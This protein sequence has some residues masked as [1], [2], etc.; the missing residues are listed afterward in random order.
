MH[1]LCP[2]DIAN[3]KNIKKIGWM[4]LDVIKGHNVE[5]EEKDPFWVAWASRAMMGEI[6]QLVVSQ[7][8][9]SSK[10]PI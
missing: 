4:K 7:P 5:K 1:S 10:L 9:E 6:R 8:N 2:T 3:K